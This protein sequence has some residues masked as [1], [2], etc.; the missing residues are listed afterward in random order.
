MGRGCYLVANVLDPQSYM[1]ITGM[2]SIYKG[3]LV[4]YMY[5]KKNRESASQV[6]FLCGKKKKRKPPEGLSE[7]RGLK[8]PLFRHTQPEELRQKKKREREMEEKWG[9]KRK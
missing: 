9:K 6:I 8:S 1:N 5:E 3:R 4:K 2:Q 7:A